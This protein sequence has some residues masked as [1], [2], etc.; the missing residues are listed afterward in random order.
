MIAPR[1]QDRLSDYD[2]VVNMPASTAPTLAHFARHRGL[3]A[4]ENAEMG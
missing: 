4:Q 1:R 2:S 3:F